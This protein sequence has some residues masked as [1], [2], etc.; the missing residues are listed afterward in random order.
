M[1]S[2]HRVASLWGARTSARVACPD[3]TLWGLQHVPMALACAEVGH[4]DVMTASSPGKTWNLAGLHC[5]FVVLQDDALR[6]RYMAVVAHAS[7]HFGSVFATSAMLAAYRLGGAWRDRLCRYFESQVLFVEEFLDAQCPQLR[8]VRPQAT[9]L[10][11]LDC[12]GA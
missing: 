7:L 2:H 6:A 4:R 11:W 1:G 3:L 5:G 9:Y 8:L 10:V 12:S